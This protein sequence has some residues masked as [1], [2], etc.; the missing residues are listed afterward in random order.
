[1]LIISLVQGLSIHGIISSCFIEYSSLLN[2]WE[3]RWII[4]VISMFVLKEINDF[5]WNLWQ[6]YNNAGFLL[7]QMCLLWHHYIVAM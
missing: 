6:V 2:E 5:V 7:F 1:M 4:N 3:M